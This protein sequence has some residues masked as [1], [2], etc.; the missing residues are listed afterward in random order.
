ML[1][2]KTRNNKYTDKGMSLVCN[3][4]LIFFKYD[5]IYKSSY[6]DSSERF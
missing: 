2:T 1:I 6:Y 3:N 5:F 4:M